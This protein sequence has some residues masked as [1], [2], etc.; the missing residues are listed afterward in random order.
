M[1]SISSSNPCLRLCC[2]SAPA[3]NIPTPAFP[4]LIGH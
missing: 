4:R 1:P 3:P 2:S